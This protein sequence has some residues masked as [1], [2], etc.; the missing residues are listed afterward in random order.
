MCSSIRRV[1]ELV[2]LFRYLLTPVPGPGA[3]V[4]VNPSAVHALAHPIRLNNGIAMAF[5]RRVRTLRDQLPC[6]TLP[7]TNDCAG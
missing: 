4:A 7:H 2:C 6:Y 1:A 5:A 3:Q